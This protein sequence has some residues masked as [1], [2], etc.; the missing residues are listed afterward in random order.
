MMGEDVE[1]SKE[2]RGETLSGGRTLPIR[3][4]VVE[5][6]L[7]VAGAA[8]GGKRIPPSGATVGENNAPFEEVCSKRK[9]RICGSDGVRGPALG[10]S[11]PEVL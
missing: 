2:D 6:R 4:P 3:P 10:R 7:D 1:L 11:W 9:V 8:N 5:G